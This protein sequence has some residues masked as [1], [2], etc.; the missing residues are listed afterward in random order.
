MKTGH[1]GVF[2]HR[3]TARLP[4]QE[5]YGPSI[6]KVFINDAILLAMEHLAR[7]RWVKVFNQEIN[8][9]LSKFK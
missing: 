2:K 1:R 4:I 9:E 8:F 5:L 3:G 7:D 6:P